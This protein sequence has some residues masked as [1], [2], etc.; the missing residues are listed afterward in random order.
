MM[1]CFEEDKLV[2]SFPVVC[3]DLVNL[4]AWKGLWI[5]CPSGGWCVTLAP[6]PLYLWCNLTGDV[7][8]LCRYCG[9]DQVADTEADWAVS[10]VSLQGDT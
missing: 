8:A 7:A 3:A 10:S 5:A 4:L 6:W 1:A 2:R 9:L